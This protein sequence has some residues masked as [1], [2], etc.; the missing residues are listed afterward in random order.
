LAGHKRP[1]IRHPIQEVKILA[2]KYWRHIKRKYRQA[3]EEGLAGK[4]HHTGI[5]DLGV[6]TREYSK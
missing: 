5:I 3:N 1:G 2:A 6:E 4:L